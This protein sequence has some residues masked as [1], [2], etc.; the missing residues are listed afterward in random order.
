MLLQARNL[1]HRRGDARQGVTIAL[2]RLDLGRGEVLFVTGPSGSGKSTLLE[3]LGLVTAP[4]AGSE[5]VLDADGAGGVDIAALWR[6]RDEAALATLRARHIGFVLQAGGLLPFLSLA[7]NIQFNRRL[8]RL[9]EETDLVAA[10]VARLGLERLLHRLPHQV[11]VG[12]A[13]RAAIARAL[14]HRPAL[15]LA[16]EPTSALHP[17]MAREVA[18]LLLE[19]AAEA[20][21]ALV[22]ASH[23]TDWEIRDGHKRLQAVPAPGYGSRFEAVA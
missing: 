5:L 18:A 22:I 19:N 11:S 23:A 6:R 10:M 12:E 1:A 8:L 13:Q 9:P 17:R 7:E 16:D 20:G 14:A 3:V 21:A 4:L 2:P 15:V